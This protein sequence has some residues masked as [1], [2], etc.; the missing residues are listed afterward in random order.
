MRADLGDFAGA[1]GDEVS[2]FSL[3]LNL[4]DESQDLQEHTMCRQPE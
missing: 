1:L 2:S 4:V 3:F